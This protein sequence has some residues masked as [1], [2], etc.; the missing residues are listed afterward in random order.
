MKKMLLVSAIIYATGHAQENYKQ[1]RVPFVKKIDERLELLKCI[2]EKEVLQ[3]AQ[4]LYKGANP[5]RPAPQ[6]PPALIVAIANRDFTMV[7]LLLEYNA[8]PNKR[9]WIWQRVPLICAV[10][11][12]QDDVVKLLLAHKAHPDL[13]NKKGH[14]ALTLACK[15]FNHSESS[16]KIIHA[17][18]DAGANPNIPNRNGRTPLHYM[19]TE[20]LK[21][22]RALIR[23]G[24]R[25]NHPDSRKYTALHKV[26]IACVQSYNKPAQGTQD[27]AAQ[28]EFKAIIQILLDAGACPDLENKFK[29]TARE[30]C[31]GTDLEALL[32]P[33]ET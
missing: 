9:D 23:A 25:V 29:I 31:H 2:E 17:L 4:L 15:C 21:L 20:N 8:D 6:L 32:K 12:F 26:V 14:T 7:K 13:T 27:K 16:E 11:E 24:A 28:Q 5:N 18:L 30:L 33:K 19:C 22:T 3:V 1:E 10:E